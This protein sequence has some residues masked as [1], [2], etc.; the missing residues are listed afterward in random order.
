MC[1]AAGAGEGRG[2]ACPGCLSSDPEA[3]SGHVARPPY[4]LPAQGPLL[5]LGCSG[6]REESIASQHCSFLRAGGSC[7]PRPR[8]PS[9]GDQRPQDMGETS[10]QEAMARAGCCAGGTGGRVPALQTSAPRGAGMGLCPTPARWQARP[11]SPQ[12]LENRP[13]Q[14]KPWPPG[15][16]LPAA[17]PGSRPLAPGP[18][19]ARAG[20]CWAPVRTGTAQPNS[21]RHQGQAWG[22]LAPRSCASHSRRGP[23]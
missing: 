21:F 17:P 18:R 12:G 3:E 16:I 19:L 20:R 4:G 15:P 6:A 14:S 2:R 22:A 7:L 13:L 9:K 11:G 23:G 5:P 1:P 8:P 10:T